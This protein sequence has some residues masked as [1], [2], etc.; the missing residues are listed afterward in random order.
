MSNSEIPSYRTKKPSRYS[1]HPRPGYNNRAMVWMEKDGELYVSGGRAALLQHI[2][3]LGSIAAAARQ[4]GL[5]YRNAWL[6][7]ESMNR[8][9]PSPLVRKNTGGVNGGRTELTDEGHKALKAYN[10]L[11]R[12]VQRM[13]R[14]E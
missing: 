1:R 12:R 7:V 11:N 10:E 8:L 4:M 9:A 3:E 14:E 6:W 13:L 2:A 5:A